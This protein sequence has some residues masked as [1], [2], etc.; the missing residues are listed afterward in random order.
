MLH[1]LTNVLSMQQ[2]RKNCQQSKHVGAK[3]SKRQYL[4]AS[5]RHIIATDRWP[6]RHPPQK[7]G[8]ESD[9]NKCTNRQVLLLFKNPVFLLTWCNQVHTCCVPKQ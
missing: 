6:A 2:C 5:N 9:S 3:I 7:R 4:A 1:S 8:L